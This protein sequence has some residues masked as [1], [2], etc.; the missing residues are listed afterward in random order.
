[1]DNKDDKGLWIKF[2]IE[3]GDTK[4]GENIYITGSSD[5][6][7][8]WKEDKITKLNTQNN[9]DAYIKFPKW[10]SD[11]IKFDKNDPKLQYKYI[12]KDNQNKINWEK[13]D[14]N[15]EL[16]LNKFFD[17]GFYIIDDGKFSDK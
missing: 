16:D 15:R 12:L 2:I 13:I 6:L 1:M 8:N 5:S 3:N 14:G 17:D 7:F 10:E 4:Y 11:F 9:K